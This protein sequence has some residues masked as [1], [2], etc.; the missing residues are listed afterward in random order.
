MRA[1][2]RLMRYAKY[3]TGA[4]PTSEN[5]P[6]NPKIWNLAREI[7]EEMKSIGLSDVTLDENCYLMGELP[8]NIDNYQGQTLGL[9]AHM[10]VSY[11]APSEDVKPQVIHYEGGDII[12]N[13]T[14]NL[15]I[16]KGTFP[17]IENYI[18]MDIVTSDGTTLLG[19]DNKAGVAEIMTMAEHLINHPEIKHGRI[20]ICFTVDEEIGR[21]GEKFNLDKFQSDFA[22]TVDGEAFGECQSETFNAFEATVKVK[23]I[24]VHPGS[25][26]NRMKNAVK[27]AEEFDGMLPPCETPEH[28]E[29]YEGFYHLM[30]FHGDI[31]NAKMEY[32]IRDHDFDKAKS[33]ADHMVEIADFLNNRYGD[34]T[35]QVI[36][37]ESYRN[38][39][40]VVAGHPKLVGIPVAVMKE[41]GVVPNLEP[42]RGGTDGAFLSGKGL[43]CPNLG[44]G[45]HNFHGRKEFAVVQE[46]DRVVELLVGIAKKVGEEKGII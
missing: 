46:M 38:M 1:Y 19:A 29:G 45:A 31:E 30:E 34:N 44:V 27:I 16:D 18:G 9:I 4:D 5:T 42:I 6:S 8:A 41:M 40:E 14:K 22:Y 21:S 37:E 12:Q 33:R 23:G 7:E 11:E 17:F 39:K 15:R 20:R 3:P 35:C 2:E 25:A 13:V 24:S 36:V 43:P 32:I 26:K 10:D 28:T